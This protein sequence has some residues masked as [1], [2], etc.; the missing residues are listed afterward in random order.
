MLKA[1]ETLEAM[2]PS[3]EERETHLRNHHLALRVLLSLGERIDREGFAQALGPSL[4]FVRSLSYLVNSARRISGTFTS[5]FAALLSLGERI[6]VRGFVHAFGAS[7]ILTRWL[8]VV[9]GSRSY[10]RGKIRSTTYQEGARGRA[11]MVPGFPRTGDALRCGP[12][13]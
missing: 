7:L 1:V 3:H 13:T 8:L 9:G 12:G 11:G 10:K 2:S 4:E 5:R 6:E